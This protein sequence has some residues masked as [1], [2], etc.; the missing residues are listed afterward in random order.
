MM[1]NS[2][3]IYRLSDRQAVIETWNPALVLHLNLAKY[4]WMNA[5]DWLVSLNK[6]KEA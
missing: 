6:G 3:I 1:S 4:G 5:H 2:W